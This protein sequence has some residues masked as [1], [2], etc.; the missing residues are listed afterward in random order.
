M[1]TEI[2]QSSL[3]LC[4]FFQPI[5]LMLGWADMA[6][7]KPQVGQKFKPKQATT[8]TNFLLVQYLVL[9][10]LANYAKT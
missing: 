8:N 6:W 5:P 3:I 7:Q 2:A 1:L 9:K 10:V 4:F